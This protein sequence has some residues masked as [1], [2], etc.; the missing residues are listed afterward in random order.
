MNKYYF[1]FLA[2]V[3]LTLAACRG[4]S[5]QPTPF[6][7]ENVE[8]HPLVTDSAAIDS[9]NNSGMVDNDAILEMPDIPTDK[10]VDMDATDAAVLNLMSGAGDGDIKEAD[11]TR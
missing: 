4:R 6:V 7:E 9:I 10:N 1:S 11:P 8:Y 5:S 3:L 2:L